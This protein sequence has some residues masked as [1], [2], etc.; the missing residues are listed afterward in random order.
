M[1]AH[2]KT[3]LLIEDDPDLGESTLD[4]LKLQHQVEWAAT[5]DDA[6]KALSKRQFDVAIVDLGLGLD[7]AVTMIKALQRFGKPLPPLII[8]SARPIAMIRE[9]VAETG[10]LMALQKPC[11]GA[12]INE[13]IE[14]VLQNGKRGDDAP[15]PTE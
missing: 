15:P 6:Y 11:S 3:V 14:F 7:N 9:A 5:A 1:T 8:F 12:V 13:A 4:I 2:E 10:A